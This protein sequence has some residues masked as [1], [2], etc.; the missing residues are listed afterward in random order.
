MKSSDTI[1]YSWEGWYGTPPCIVKAE[2]PPKVLAAFHIEPAEAIA[3][4]LAET[5]EQLPGAPV[6]LGAPVRVSERIV[7]RKLLATPDRAID[8][9]YLDWVDVQVRVHRWHQVEIN[10]HIAIAGTDLKG[11]LVALIQSR[12][13]K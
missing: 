12:V 9:E 8:L 4:V 3:S 2:P 11:E 1:L 6:S 5:L 10:N 7:E 13:A